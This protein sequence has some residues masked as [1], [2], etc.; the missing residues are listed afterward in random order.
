MLLKHPLCWLLALA[1]AL[2]LLVLAGPMSTDISIDG[3]EYCRI[4]EELVAEGR[5]AGMLPGPATMM[6]PL[7]PVLVAGWMMASGWNAV[8]SARSVSLLASLVCVLL[9]YQLAR[10]F[11]GELAGFA[12]AALLATAPLFILLGSAEFAEPVQ[13]ALLLAALTVLL[14][15]VEGPTPFQAVLSGC[16]FGL[17]ALAR[18]ETLALGVLAALFIAVRGDARA[19]ARMLRASLF[20]LLLLAQLLPW[21][22]HLHD[23]T[24]RWRLEVKSGRVAATVLRSADGLEY[25]AANYGLGPTGAVEGPWLRPDLPVTEPAHGLLGAWLARPLDLASH[26]GRNLARYLWWLASGVALGSVLLLAAMLPALW[27][28]RD[29]RL[30]LLLVLASAM[31]LL[32]SLY[33]P[34]PRYA[35]PAVLLL[36]IV[37]ALGLARMAA[38]ARHPRVLIMAAAVLLA[39]TSLR[40]APDAFH[41]LVEGRDASC[42]RAAKALGAKGPHRD[43]ARVPARGS[44][45]LADDARL[46]F[47]MGARWL[48][49]PAAPSSE[50]LARYAAGTG[51]SV[52][53]W[54]T[55]DGNAA[56]PGPAIDPQAVTGW[57]RLDPAPA[58][59]CILVR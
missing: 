44:L 2:R 24:G 25:A 15:R 20:L 11:G 45:W 30:L 6:P 16:L 50:T 13:C 40:G 56:R 27:P 51:A 17:A 43:A 1:L 38:R 49:L 4:A 34:V 37:A 46:P 35:A 59:W 26:S 18:I 53:A 8:D 48:P 5:I 28:L 33:K 55:D 47:H 9:A 10:R 41:G 54:R 29:A 32:A 57:R 31:L 21:A 22:A 36:E 52:M 12:A 23:A 39:L 19:P 14:R 7:Q 58:G 42:L 3:A